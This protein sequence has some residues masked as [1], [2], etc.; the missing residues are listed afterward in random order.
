LRHFIRIQLSGHLSGAVLVLLRLIQNI[1]LLA[2][3][4]I[5]LQILAQRIKSRPAE[6]HIAEGLLFGLACI[7]GMMAPVH[8]APGIIYDG[9]SLVLSLAGLFSGPIPDIIAALISGAYRLYLG[10]SGAW[11]GTAVVVEA[12]LLGIGLHYLRSRNERLET[13]AI[14]L[15]FGFLVHGLVVSARGRWLVGVAAFWVGSFHRLF[16]CLFTGCAD[17]H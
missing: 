10:G 17:F 5:G 6:L 3:L 4:A 11:V 8:F 1:A 14:L 12:T 13:P 7:V 16:S 2:M 15:L 9:R